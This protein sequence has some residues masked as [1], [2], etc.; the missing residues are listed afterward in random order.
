LGSEADPIKD[1]QDRHVDVSFDEP[2]PE[3]RS[4][5]LVL[6]LSG[7]FANHEAHTRVDTWA[8]KITDRGFRLHI[9]S[10][11][12]STVFSAKI[13]WV[14]VPAGRDSQVHSIPSHAPPREYI[15][16]GGPVGTGCTA[17][18]WRAMHR[19]TGV[20][21][22][23]K[24]CIV[25]FKQREKG[26]QRELQTL[27]RLPQHCNLL[28]YHDHM[29]VSDRLHMVT[30]YIDALKLSDLVPGPNG[31]WSTVHHPGTM[32]GWMAQL[33]D[34]LACMHSA[35]IWHR[36]LHSENILIERTASGGPSEATGALRIIDFGAAKV[37]EAVAGPQKMSNKAGWYHFLSPERRRGEAF[38]D[39]DDVW[40]AGIN[41]LLVSTGRL[42]TKRE[43]CGKDGEDFPLLPLVVR[44]AVE[45]CP[46]TMQDAVGAVLISEPE[47]RP[48]AEVA[49][50]HVRGLLE[51]HGRAQGRGCKRA[52]S[53]TPPKVQSPHVPLT[54]ISLR[55]LRIVPPKLQNSLIRRVK[56]RFEGKL[57]FSGPIE[58]FA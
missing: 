49:R 36:D 53:R 13:A 6:A 43:D 38:D 51:A 7:L 55:A 46:L 18:T 12:D 16:M 14:A 48:T 26:F 58:C 37:H 41:F 8:E 4:P 54:D 3:G 5:S 31:P 25:P 19:D 1:G 29:I 33:F 32:L 44:Q 35:G 42:I 23:V 28:R 40:A 11:A 22:A 2:F 10:W 27:R 56:H 20:I 57:S 50:K 47:A 39:R 52:L 21:C 30:E 24:T 9:K 17:V 34:G 45:E 15:A